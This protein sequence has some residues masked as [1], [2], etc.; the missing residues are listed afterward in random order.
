MSVQ[1][2]WAVSAWKEQLESKGQYH[3]DV[4]DTVHQYPHATKV[5]R[6]FFTLDAAINCYCTLRALGLPAFKSWLS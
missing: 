6:R 2:Q 3:E 1:G 4:W 5:E